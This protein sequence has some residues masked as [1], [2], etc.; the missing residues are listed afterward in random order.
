MALSRTG[1][2]TT[3]PRTRNSYSRGLDQKCVFPGL[4]SL[5]LKTLVPDDR[6]LPV[7]TN[8]MPKINPCPLSVPQTKPNV[9]PSVKVPRNL[10]SKFN[11]WLVLSDL[12]I[13]A[14]T[15]LV[16]CI[17]FPYNF[18]YL[19]SSFP[20][21]LMSNILLVSNV[22]LSECTIIYLSIYQLEYFGCFQVLEAWNEAAISAT[23]VFV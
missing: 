23:Q 17:V 15:F 22:S 2:D 8:N 19:N 14:S 18:L 5:H 13:M 10:T 3:S 1:G 7:H 6:E 21:L 9:S 20:F 11:V 16:I 12:Y 4:S